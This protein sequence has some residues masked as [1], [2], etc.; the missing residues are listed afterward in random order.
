MSASPKLRDLIRVA[1]IVAA[2]WSL[3]SYLY[4]W[5]EPRVGAQ[6]GYNDAPIVFA[7]FYA[8]WSAMAFAI[9]QRDYR[10]LGDLSATWGRGAAIAVA[11]FVAAAF[12]L[13]VAFKLPTMEWDRPNTPVQFFHAT[14]WYAVPK[15][16]EILFQ[17][18][19]VA[20]LVAAV[21]RQGYRLWQISCVVAV[22]FGAFHL[23]LGLSYPNPLYVMRYSVA[24]TIF[25]ALVPVFL[26]RVPNGFL[27]S[28]AV[29]WIYYAVDYVAIHLVFGASA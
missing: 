25:G 26:L 20:A 1:A 5:L 12:V 14:G 22:L 17:Q 27:I 8:L 23:T 18:L 3:S 9:F 10:R 11:V 15:S 13:T 16:M 28:Y 4:F 6:I 19:L 24:A 21:W 7:F 29:H 2:L